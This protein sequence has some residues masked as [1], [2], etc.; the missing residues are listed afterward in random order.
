MSEVVKAYSSDPEVFERGVKVVSNHMRRG[1]MAPVR[2]CEHQGVWIAASEL[3]V[4]EQDVHELGG[5][6][7]STVCRRAL[8]RRLARPGVKG[9]ADVHI[10][11]IEVEIAPSEGQELALP[12]PS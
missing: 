8:G 4:S 6:G 10:S 3:L 9:L 11:T 12:R 7:D 5:E 2:S 1:H